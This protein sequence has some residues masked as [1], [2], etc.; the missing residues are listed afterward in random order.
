MKPIA[1]RLGG[2]TFV[3]SFILVVA[4]ALRFYGFPNTPFTFDEVSAWSRTNFTNFSDL[5]HQ[6]I[7]P[8]GHPA[9][10]QVTLNF[11]H[12]TFGEEEW[13]FK[14]PFLLMG[15]A[16][17]WLI[18][19]IG[20]V[21]FG[22][23]CGLL[24]AAFIATI[25]FTVMYSQIARPYASGLFFVLLTVRCW[26]ACLIEKRSD[27]W[28]IGFVLSGALCAY[29]HYFSLLMAAVIGIT[30]LFFIDRETRTKYLL[31][32]IAAIVLFLPH[33]SITIH[34]F[35]IG[36]VAWLSK[37]TIGFA[38]Q[39]VHYIFEFSNV[40]LFTTAAIALLGAALS[41]SKRFGFHQSVSNVSKNSLRIICAA[42]FIT[43]IAIGFF[44]STFRTPVLQHSV[45]IFSLP[46]LP[47]LLF[48]FFPTLNWK[49]TATLV[50]I[51][52]SANVYGLVCVRN[53]YNVFYNQQF[54]RFIIKTK[55]ATETQRGKGLL[56]LNESETYTSYYQRK[57]NTQLPFVYWPD[58]IS[59]NPNTFRQFLDSSNADYVV[60]CNIPYDN[61]LLIKEQFSFLVDKEE[62]ASY[63]FFVFAK[64]ADKALPNDIIFNEQIVKPDS[65]VQTIHSEF[66]P[67]FSKP[68]YKIITN[69]YNQLNAELHVR[70]LP[71][72]CK[73]SVVFSIEDSTKSF[74]WFEKPL[75]DFIRADSTEG[76]ARI[77]Y[78]MR[79]VELGSAKPNI[80]V[81]V[82]NK[83][84]E[85]F[86]VDAMQVELEEGN[87]LI[88]GLFEPVPSPCTR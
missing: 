79:D 35:G 62:G 43:P 46:F 32:C 78:N 66:G 28:L 69:V 57:Y 52:M 31:A 21:W 39:H 7:A 76:I 71:L 49:T 74:V 6:G 24:T 29:N 56:L 25:Q 87:P 11:I 3:V 88:Y 44:Y 72:N 37:P 18:Y 5:L 68:Y 22:E 23:T 10:I 14:L 45:L 9:L 17:V 30:G 19:K 63:S 2:N 73:A 36:G 83:A 15:I 33:L 4:A 42:W 54:D 47:L 86:T 51:M 26:S 20:N 8:D 67:T 64:S 58:F 60:A 1:K 12:Q 85:S 81:Y 38:L 16:S 53:H 82:W 50:L 27:V 80:K 75:R 84:F 40:V 65:N 13:K 61:V 34:Q 77:T 70:N 59:T 41:F 55:Q 48:S